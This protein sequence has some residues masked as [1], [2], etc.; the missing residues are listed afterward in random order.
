MNQEMVLALLKII[1]SCDDEEIDP[2]EEASVHD[3]MHKPRACLPKDKVVLRICQLFHLH[4]HSSHEEDPTSSNQLL[5]VQTFSPF[6]T[7]RMLQ[8]LAH[9]HAVQIITKLIRRLNPEDWDLPVYLL[10]KIVTSSHDTVQELAD[11][12]GLQPS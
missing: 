12:G 7:N 8:V 6:R 9:S 1:M 4:L 3:F 2:V 11:N 5:K 10:T